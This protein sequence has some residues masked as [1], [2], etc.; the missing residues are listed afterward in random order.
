M[1][2]KNILNRKGKQIGAV[3]LTVALAFGLLTGCG[4][5]GNQNSC[6]ANRKG[7]PL[8]FIIKAM[9]TIHLSA[10]ME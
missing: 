8:T 3:L 1:K 7:E 10:M 6:S 2:G 9:D 5:S 4:S